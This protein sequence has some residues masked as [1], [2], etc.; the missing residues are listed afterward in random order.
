[1]MQVKLL[2]TK[3]V[4]TFRKL[5]V[6]YVFIKAR[7][8]IISML[9]RHFINN[10]ENKKNWE[11]L[12]D[13]YK[14]KRAFLIGNGPS[15]N[16]TPL[17]LLKNEFTMAFNRFYIMKERLNWY[18]T[19]YSVVDN[20]VL[21]DLVGEI[22]S[23]VEK[24]EL[25]F[26]PDIH[27]RGDNFIKRIGKNKKILWIHQ[28]FGEGFSLNLPK[29]YPGGSVIYEGL[30]ILNHLG[31]K[32]IIIIGVDMNFELHNTAKNLDTRGVDIISQDDDDPNHF[33]PRYFG[34]NRKYHQ[35]EKQV[36][37]E[38]FKNLH[39]L[40]KHMDKFALKV[41]NAGIDSKVECFPKKNFIDLFNYSEN[42]VKLIF[43]SLITEKSRYKSLMDFEQSSIFVNNPEKWKP[44]LD[45]FYTYK[46]LGLRLIK[47]VIFTHIP[48]G[49]Y[50]NRYYFIKTINQ[51]K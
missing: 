39:Y 20:L 51:I 5:G 43:E 24:T 44:E 41:I 49:P 37:H 33:D 38:I 16:K 14:G 1:M 35:P 34:K 3:T 8:R 29:I 11:K 2:I 26:F 42:D 21:D 50:N 18:P 40:G 22:N 36:I 46:E 28:L 48:I 15:L 13:K 7:R 23:I 6:K 19:F 9:L 31:F 27:F 47:K 17:Y 32:E 45:D 12:K 4:D 25:S 30:Q 10:Q